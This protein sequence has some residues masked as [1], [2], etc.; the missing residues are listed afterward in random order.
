[1]MMMMMMMMMMNSA[2]EH[3]AE[4]CHILVLEPD[5]GGAQQMNSAATLQQMV[6]VDDVKNG[7]ILGEFS[8]ISCV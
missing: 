6:D 5:S 3:L 8:G 2:T 7:E 1:M 4:I